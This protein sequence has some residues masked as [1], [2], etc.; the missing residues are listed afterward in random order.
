MLQKV[1]PYLAWGLLALLAIFILL[2]LHSV[3]V[4]LLVMEVHLPAALLIAGSASLGAG[5]MLLFL[6]MRKLR[7]ENPPPP[8]PAA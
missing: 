6:L 3:K 5:A 7:G 8:P 2:N 4:R 1:R